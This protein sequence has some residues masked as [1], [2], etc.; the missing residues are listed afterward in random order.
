MKKRLTVNFGLKILA[1]FIAL[2]MWLIVVNIDDPV[3][4]KTY[5]GIPVQ[6]INEEVVTSANRTY[7][8]VD[9]TQ[10]VSVTVTAQRSVLNDIKAEDIVAIADMKEISL[11]T[12][13]PIEVKIEGYK[14]DSAV[15]NPRNLQIQIDDEAKN[16]FPITPTTLGT[17]REGYVIGELKA[18][19]EK[20]TIRGPKT[21]IDSINRVVAEVDVSGLSSDTE[22]EAR[23]VLYDA[24][25]NVID[26]SL[27][28]NNLGKE[29]LTVEVKLHQ[30]KSV[31][32]ELDTAMVSAAEGYKISGISV[33]PQEVRIS[34]SKSA[35][36]KVTEITIPASALTAINLTQRTERSIDISQY[37][38][39]DVA[40]VDE[41]ADNVVVTIS[42]EKPGAKNYEVSTSA[43][44]VNNLDSRLELS[45]GTVVDLEIQ[46]KGPSEV[47][48]VFSIAKKVSIDLK[49]YTK[50]GTYTVP[51]TVELPAGCSLVNEV[52]VEVILDEKQ[53]QEE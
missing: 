8:I 18:N 53:E 11:G 29:G 9:D 31:K 48:S 28:A 35:L 25:N 44:T 12:Q 20:V 16:N 26:Q 7:Q 50:P 23:L 6:V 5:T 24:N 49:D 37:L 17:V 43:I 27:L 14:Y 45:Y 51:V 39:E 22:V 13:I 21:V 30:I 38:P 34:G 52:S 1:F 46:I 33:E 40:L 36:T 47:L 2:F 3:T 10:E 15:S 32:V 4:D 41:N 42:V 19:P